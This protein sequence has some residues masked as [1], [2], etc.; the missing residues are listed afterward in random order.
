MRLDTVEYNKYEDSSISVEVKNTLN[1]IINKLRVDLDNVDT[2]ELD[3]VWGNTVAN[4]LGDI[5]FKEIRKS[6]KVLEISEWT[7]SGRSAGYY[8]LI[9]NFDVEEL[10]EAEDYTDLEGNYYQYLGNEIRNNSQLR[11]LQTLLNSDLNKITKIIKNVIDTKGVQI[12]KYLVKD[13]TITESNGLKE[14]VE[15]EGMVIG[16]SSLTGTRVNAVQDF[17]DTNNLNHRTMFNYL[18]NGN[19]SVR[20]DFAA[21]LSGYPGNKYQKMFIS[22]FGLN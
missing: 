11:K 13:L 8:T 6:C 1:Y 10:E 17:I 18:K 7:F 5:A 21:A 3:M 2:E 20:H 12:V 22:K 19:A 9:N 16:I 15:P 14:V 4:E